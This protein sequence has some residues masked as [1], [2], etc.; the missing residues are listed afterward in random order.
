MNVKNVFKPKAAALA[1]AM[2]LAFA[3][4][5][6]AAPTATIFGGLGIAGYYNSPTANPG[7][8]SAYDISSDGSRIGIKG[9][10]GKSGDTTFIY[11]YMMNVNP[12]KSGS[13][14]SPTTYTAF[15]GAKGD[16]GTFMAGRPF[17]PFY[18]DIVSVFNPFWWFYTTNVD[19]KQMDKAIVYTTPTMGGFNMSVSLS[20]MSKGSASGS[21]D[22]TNFTL[23]G[24]YTTGPFSFAAGYVG[25]SKYGDGVNEYSA[26]SST[27]VWGTPINEYAGERLKSK[28]AARGSYNEGPL[29]VNLGLFSYKPTSMIYNGTTTTAQNDNAINTVNLW[30]SYM[31]APKWTLMGEFSSTSQSGSNP[32]KGTFTTFSVAY[33]PVD[34]VA[35]FA[36][37]QYYSK[38]AAVSGLDG[39]NSGTRA[40]GQF[41][42]GGYY[43][44]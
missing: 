38:D 44:F 41:A 30:A 11:E 16:W 31:V 18:T 19:I 13:G 9:D 39:V 20:N 6:H 10:L 8:S 33:A 12:V 21:K 40:N 2:G 36:E 32:K 14:S 23:T 25:F 22:E 35:L 24:T 17:T 4:A 37:Y 5:A 26:S 43:S 1:A 15:L 7:D 27:T 29:S 34:A 42:V 28:V 3:G